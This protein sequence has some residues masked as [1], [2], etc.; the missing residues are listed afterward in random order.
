MLYTELSVSAQATFAGLDVAARDLDVRRTVAAVPGG[1][2][3][4]QDKGR[5]YWYFQQK[6]PDGK[7]QQVFVGPDDEA[8]RA[9]IERH[10]AADAVQGKEALQKLARAAI[11]LGCPEIP[12]KHGR[13]IGCLLDHGFF[14]ATLEV[15]GVFA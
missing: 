15:H 2:V 6:Q 14:K 7:V 8:T 12:L 3:K 13:V 5:G 11:A 4:K 1:F 9:L 10:G